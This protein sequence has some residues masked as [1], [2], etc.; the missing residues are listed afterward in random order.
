MADEVR[1]TSLMSRKRLDSRLAED[2]V[3]LAAPHVPAALIPLGDS[4]IFIYRVRA[5][6]AVSELP[7]EQ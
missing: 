1:M 3:P 5:G 6:A 4:L 7:S 2:P